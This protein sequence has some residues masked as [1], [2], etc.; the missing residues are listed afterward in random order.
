MAKVESVSKK[1]RNVQQLSGQKLAIKKFGTKITQNSAQLKLASSINAKTSDFTCFLLKGNS[2]MNPLSYILSK[3]WNLQSQKLT[4]ERFSAAEFSKST[5]PWTYCNDQTKVNE[6]DQLV[7]RKIDSKKWNAKGCHGNVKTKTFWF[8]FCSR[9]TTKALK[10]IAQGSWS[11]S[12]FWL[13]SW[14]HFFAMPENMKQQLAILGKKQAW[15]DSG[16]AS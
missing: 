7:P 1:I 2:K 4:E 11:Y 15:D 8:S 6:F 16:V 14:P 13:Q 10:C 3:N 9:K 5:R 12:T